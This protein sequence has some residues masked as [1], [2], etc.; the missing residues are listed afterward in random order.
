MA[1]IIPALTKSV[2][3]KMT[4]GEKRFARRL[5]SHLEDDYLVWY[6]VPIGPKRRFPDFIIL[7]P[8][9]GLLI[10]EVKDWKGTSMK[11]MRKESVDLL[12]P[13]GLKTVAHPLDQ[14]RECAF[15]V[16]N[17]LERDKKLV[18][19]DGRYK[20]KL[21]M[22]YGYGCVFPNITSKQ[23]QKA[24][25][26]EVRDLILADHL[27]IYKDEMTESIDHEDFQ[28]K[29]W[30][31]FIHQFGDTLTLPEIDRVRYHLFPDV[32]IDVK[33]D[34]MFEDD[35]NDMPDIIRV[36]D[37]EQEKLARNLGNGHRV[38]HGVAGSGKTMILGFRCEYLSQ[39]NAGAVL[40]LCYN[41]TLAASLRDYVTKKGIQHNVQVYHFHDWC[42]EQMTMYN[43]DILKSDKEAYERQVDT[44]IH[45]VE[46]GYIPRGQYDAILIDEGHDFEDKWLKL[47]VQ[48][49][50][51]ESDQIL[52]MYDD[53][54]AIYGRKS[55]LSFSL[56]SVG[57][58][59]QGRTKIL[60]INYRNT[61][62]IIEYA[63]D[64]ASYFLDVEKTEDKDD[65]IVPAAS[66]RSGPTPVIKRFGSLDEEIE[67]AV[68][69]AVKW[70]NENEK[71]N[72]VGILCVTK[73]QMKLVG[74]KLKAAGVKASIC[75]SKKNKLAYPGENKIGVMTIHNSKG[76]EFP[77]VVLVGV[78]N[79]PGKNESI[80]DAAKLLYVG[81][82]RACE[83]LILT[84][85]K[86][87]EICSK[88]H[89]AA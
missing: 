29:L 17:L 14:A 81:M 19:R 40:V 53:A 43:V 76:L 89:L 65:L 73:Y 88:L 32:R 38:I 34:D 20:G 51:P 78:G 48:M 24:L 49:V 16:V 11:K 62:Q 4:S 26:E 12:T 47:I 1:E 21:S 10:I 66:G 33:Q 70:G 31:M 86:D 36:M 35:E 59:A 77:N 3:S 60:K 50:N 52:L 44:V 37:I 23:M 72:Q 68:R 87:S 58:N 85:S 46:E 83:R 22:P 18:R 27:T 28:S 67:F 39:I 8:S 64:F 41:V 84:S 2:L 82:T 6:D 57:I 75:N 5:Q 42:K 63:Y 30:G 13:N 56:S 74:Q 79:L 80:E 25:P 54:Q 45:G 61:Q 71:S 69:C 9:R 7:H 55:G 15:S